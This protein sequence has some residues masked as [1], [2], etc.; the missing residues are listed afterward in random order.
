MQTPIE[1][2][3]AEDDDAAPADAR[4]T[5]GRRR[6]VTAGR[7]SPLLLLVATVAVLW[8]YEVP[9]ATTAIFALY[10]ALGI[11]LPGTLWWRYLLRGRGWF[12]ADVAAGLV[13]GYLGEVFCYV[14]ARLLGQPLLV[15]AWPLAT[16]TLFTTVPG[17]RRYWRSDP[18]ADRPPPLWRWCMTGLA[19][20]PLLWSVKFYRIY[21]LRFPYNS[22]PDTDSTF[23]LALLGEAKH[24]MPMVVPWVTDEPLYYH[25][26][27]YPEMAATSWVTGIEPNVLL[28]RLSMLPMLMAFTVLVGLLAGKVTGRWWTSVA[29]SGVTLFVLS[30]HPY[31]WRVGEFYRNL[32]FSGLD[33]GSSL[34]LTVWTGPTQTFGALLFVPL[35]LML[36]DLLRDHR[37]G[38]RW[39]LFTL[40][41][42]GVMGGKATYVPL[43]LCGLL[44]VVAV[45]LLL[46]RRLHR[47]ALI[48]LG[49]AVAAL[50]FSQLVLFG[51]TSQ[52]TA[53]K[54]LADVVTGG[55][56]IST[57][58]STGEVTGRLLVLAALT[59][60]AWVCVWAGLAG[61]LRRR[62][63]AP[64]LTVLVGVGI[65]GAAATMLTGQSGD[66]QRFFLE[67][68]RP[69]LSVAAVAGL[70]A[71]LPAGRMTVRRA[72]PLLGAA[73][74]GVVVVQAIQS[75][76]R[77]SVPNVGNTGSYGN[78]TRAIVLPHVALLGFAVVSL[79]ALLVARRWLP[80]TRGT[81][82]ALVVALLAGYGLNTTVQNFYLVLRE[83]RQHGWRDVIHGSPLVSEG[84]LEAGRW[85]RDHSSPDDLVATNAHCV[86]LEGRC[87]NLHFSMTAYSERRM[88][89]EGWGFSTTA[90]EEA[91]RLDTWVG[92]VP[93][94]KPRILADN[95]AV[96]EDPSPETVDV[97]R[98]R[99]RIRWLF[100]DET[101]SDVSPA[102]STF[103]TERYRSG[104]CVVY[105]LPRS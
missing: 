29:A 62:L 69:Y 47:G 50:A 84:T 61:L 99:Y 73:L 72:L 35:V 32:A 65:S 53:L 76:G 67:A 85:L 79:V 36:V 86:T 37:D 64:E 34:R 31:Q 3:L 25:W 89:V 98:D 51:A 21:G 100:V 12:V 59:V 80:I 45:E 91:A 68:A 71:L 97:L 58:Y 40:L 18:G 104:V 83:S 6:L 48:A 28:L 39:A 70:V 17:L 43:L 92:H 75:S 20:V 16:V 82:A 90:H 7:L 5:A 46:R 93:Y 81:A 57:G 96:F 54:P 105:E 66:S 103:A 55:L 38:R 24:H 60:F 49:P 78:L 101:Q 15:L 88:L 102:L 4:A 52:G 14:A 44:L 94:W 9:P 56:G 33:D 74:L 11:T 19:A 41:L 42:A 26:F 87:S 27:T 13:L 10:L 1:V 8:C 95:D 30:P 23:H 22:A 63:P 2:T 77:G